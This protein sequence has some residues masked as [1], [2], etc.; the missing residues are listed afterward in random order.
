MYQR[1]NL[2][3]KTTDLRNSRIFNIFLTLSNHYWGTERFLIRSHNQK[4]LHY[5]IHEQKVIL[6][7]VFVPRNFSEH[8]RD[9]TR[10][11]NLKI[12]I[13]KQQKLWAFLINSELSWSLVP[14]VDMQ[15]SET[16]HIISS[17]TTHKQL[18][19]Y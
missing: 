9:F 12:L 2:K 10:C 8:V 17:L 18:P 7:Q 4:G 6:F 15:Y 14:Y 1:T 5:D 16:P 13:S 11:Y 19:S 3:D